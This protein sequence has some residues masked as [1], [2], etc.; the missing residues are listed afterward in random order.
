MKSKVVS[1]AALCLLGTF[2][3]MTF[4][5]ASTINLDFEDGGPSGH[6]PAPVGGYNVGGFGFAFSNATYAFAPSGSAPY[7]LALGHVVIAPYVQKTNGIGYEPITVDFDFGAMNVS[8]GIAVS[9]VVAIVNTLSAYGPSD[10]LIDSD[11][12]TGIV[13]A[14]PY[15]LSV[16]GSDIRRII[17]DGQ[18][19]A[20]R[21]S[22]FSSEFDNLSVTA[23]PLPTEPVPIPPTV[24]LFGSGLAGLGWLARQRKS[25]VR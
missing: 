11:S 22:G 19:W 5:E 25:R 7:I 6:G 20:D 15:T 24:A 18:I 10:K 13:G 14:G 2:D 12:I 8:V 3:S 17:I 23:T 21:F 16:N 9:G 4:A 1:L